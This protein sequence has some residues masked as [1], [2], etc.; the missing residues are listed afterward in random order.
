MNE[1]FGHYTSTIY[2]KEAQQTTMLMMGFF[3]FFLLRSTLQWYSQVILVLIHSR[4]SPEIL[5]SDKKK[6]QPQQ[7]K[8]ILAK[9]KFRLIHSD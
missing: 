5:C 1:L 2:S 3:R 6:T 7:Q 4:A 9:S 8:K